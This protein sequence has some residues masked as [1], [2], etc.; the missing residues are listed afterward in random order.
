[1]TRYFFI[2]VLVP[3]SI[4]IPLCIGLFNV[5][6]FRRYD[7]NIFIYLFMSGII[8][9]VVS[10]L[11]YNK[12]NNMPLFHIYTM[13]EFVC[14]ILFFI[15]LYNNRTYRIVAA[16]V[17]ILFLFLAIIN[18]IIVQSLFIFNTHSRSLEALIIICYCIYY[19]YTQI[20]KEELVL[21]T[22]KNLYVTGFFIYFCSAF[23]IF[24]MSNITLGISKEL[25][26]ILWN[27]HAFMVLIMY[28]FISIG[29]YLGKIS[30]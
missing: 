12:I 10:I 14:I 29:L 17:V 16:I 6:Y 22:A 26:W 19:Y 4:I 21:Y 1:M 20:K 9:L 28:V 11:A 2:S 25:N 7:W 30:R 23:I 5:R 18:S 13:L 15:A 3:L 8:N 27:I 24:M